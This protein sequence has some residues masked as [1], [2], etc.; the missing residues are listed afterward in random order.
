MDFKKYYNY[1]D[2][3][4]MRTAQDS[5]NRSNDR[6]EEIIAFAKEANYRKIGIAFCT[7]LTKETSVLEN[8]LLSEG[9]QVEKVNCKFGKLPL[10]DLLD[11]YMG[12]SCN[13]V[14]QALFLNEKY[15]E[16][17]IVLGLCLGHDMIFNAKSDAPVTTLIVKDRKLKHQTIERLTNAT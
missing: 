12:I 7:S 1:S 10:A 6:I 16:L 13:P 15:T 4:I 11:G 9:F 3:A 5:L 14:G 17:N 8:I 2:K